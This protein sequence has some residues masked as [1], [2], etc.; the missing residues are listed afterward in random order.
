MGRRFFIA[1]GAAARIFAEV[2][3][4][5]VL[6]EKESAA[7]LKKLIGEDR[8]VPGSDFPFDLC[9]WPP[10]DPGRKGAESLLNVA[11]EA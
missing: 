5:S 4:D 7:Y 9:Q 11:I 2:W 3:F 1:F 8:L 6:W 10:L